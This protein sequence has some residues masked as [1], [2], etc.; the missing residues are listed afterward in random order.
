MRRARP[1]LGTFVEIA[2]ADAA[3]PAMHAA[4]DAAY[5]V[6]RQVHELMSFHEEGSDVS[7]VNR[8]AWGKAGSRACPDVSGS[9]N[10]D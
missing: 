8:E 7:R 3:L 1:L 6:V 4:M 10:R 2:V 5:A 9:T